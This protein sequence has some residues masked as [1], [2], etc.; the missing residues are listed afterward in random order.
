M[1]IILKTRFNLVYVVFIINKY[2]FNFIDIHWKTVKRIFC[3]I[4]KT[5]DLRFIF[6]ETFEFF[7]EYIDVD[8]KK[9]RNTRRFT[10]EYVFNVKNEVINWS[11]K[12]QSIIVFSIYKI[13]FIS[14]IQIIKEI[15][16]LSKLLK[17]INFERSSSL[18]F[19]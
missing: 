3:Y 12:W 17:Q 16:W 13:E 8:W 10:S 9:N 11:F 4:Q 2:I 6:N 14:Q 19:L 5:F 7:V 15:I 1:Y 18:K